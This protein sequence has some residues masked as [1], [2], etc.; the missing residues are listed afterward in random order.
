[1]SL[2][3]NKP[4]VQSVGCCGAVMLHKRV[5]SYRNILLPLWD[6][7]EALQQRGK[8]KAK[9]KADNLQEGFLT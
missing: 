3:R 4:H 7:L 1:M 5:R 9:E 2:Q 6:N 8:K